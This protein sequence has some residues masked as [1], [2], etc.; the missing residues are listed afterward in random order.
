MSGCLPLRSITLAH[1]LVASSAQS[2]FQ[3]VRAAALNVYGL[4][5]HSQRI[6]EFEDLVRQMVHPDTQLRLQ[7][8]SDALDHSFFVGTKHRIPASAASPSRSL[9]P[10][11]CLTPQRQTQASPAVRASDS[12]STKKGIKRA[13]NRDSLIRVYADPATP[14]PTRALNATQPANDAL[15]M[16]PVL[17][18]HPSVSSRY[19]SSSSGAGRA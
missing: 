5:V 7:K 18:R 10:S 2:I 4:P 8:C 14:S 17:Y 11:A 19:L 16:Q 13:G 1:C 6:A 3:S 15:L 9:Q 12:R